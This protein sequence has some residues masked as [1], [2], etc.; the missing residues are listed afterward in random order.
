MGSEVF[1]Q[2]PEDWERHDVPPRHFGVEIP[3]EQAKQA[4]IASVDQQARA[5]IAQ[6]HPVDA[7]DPPLMGSGK[8]DPD[9]E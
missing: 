1:K 6:M 4:K 2:H 9:C 3:G 7:E 5:K 8:E